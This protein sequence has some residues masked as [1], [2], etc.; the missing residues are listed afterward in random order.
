MIMRLTILLTGFVAAVVTPAAPATARATATA[1]ATAAIRH[2]IDD[3]LVTLLARSEARAPVRVIV[4]L[5][6]RPSAAAVAAQEDAAGGFTVWHRLAVSGAYAATM[7]A[8]QVRTIAARRDTVAVHLDHLHHAA[9]DTARREFGVDKATV[10]FGV[11][12][13][14]ARDGVKHWSVADGSIAV[15]DTGID[16]GHRDLDE[17]QVIHFEGFI[18]SPSAGCNPSVGPLAPFDDDDVG[19]G[20]HVAS[21]AAGQGD[22]DATRHGVAPGAALVGLKVLDCNGNGADSDIVAAVDWAIANKATWGIRVMNLSIGCPVLNPQAGCP[23]SNGLDALSRAVNRATAAGIATFVAAGNSGPGAAT[24]ES[25]GAARFAISVGAMADPKDVA[26]SFPAG[27]TLGSFS[28]RG[29]TTD[30][31]TKP[32]IVAPGVDIVA[33]CSRSVAACSGSPTFYQRLSGTS[34][35]SPFSAGVGFLVLSINPALAPSG[36]PCNGCPDGVDPASMRDPVK[37]MLTGTAVPMG[38]SA[39]HNDFGA[40]RLDAYAALAQAATTVGGP[41]SLGGPPVPCHAFRSGSLTGLGVGNAAT[42]NVPVLDPTQWPI[43]ATLIA[44]NF[45]SSTNPDLKLELL[46]PSNVI[47]TTADGNTRQETFATT[48]TATGT[49][50]VRVSA[51]SGTT[52]IPFS[53][54]ISGPPL[55][56]SDANGPDCKPGVVLT[57][58]FGAPSLFEKGAT[59][60]TYTVALRTK[61]T[62]PVTVTPATDGR[63]TV[64]PSALTFDTVNWSTPQTITVRAVDDGIVESLRSTS[65]IAHTASSN[66]PSYNGSAV[67]QFAVTVTDD[68]VAGLGGAGYWLTAADGGIFTFGTARF[69]GSTGAIRLNQPIVGMAPTTNG[70]GYW[71]VARDGGIFAFGDA[72]FF[73]S[74]GAIRLNQPIVG[75]APTRSGNGYWLV[76]A[77]GGIF[78][79]GDAAFFG[80]TGAIRLNQPIV[81][82]AATWQGAGYWLVARDGGIFAFGDAAFFG[83][84]GAIRLNQPI[85]GMAPTVAGYW[86]VARDGGIFAFGDAPFHGSTGSLT[87]NAPIVGMAG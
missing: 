85:V 73:G 26:G 17:G 69:F 51:N 21:I 62:A 36:T 54:E 68:D 78:A 22:A 74:T 72:A 31:R 82:M 80:S 32:D 59:A 45:V 5:D 6:R 24:M 49:W 13:D 18:P 47:V 33:A 9:L 53:L 28:S 71:L 70:N 34:M 7:T 84:T 10:D 86:L 61:P 38:P 15:L 16:A 44:T 30:G 81:G 50:V 57:R 19:H 75:M 37:E 79:F 83:S 87:L 8:D 11:N 4:D 41:A 60:D 35:A 3:D 1:P 43:A 40:G 58:R 23:V 39:N 20:T 46:N 77:D 29:P 66:D 2:H 12:G 65:A 27:F 64:S 76:A 25:P 55:S 67:P 14:T 48:P 56:P 63:V 42:F 52:P